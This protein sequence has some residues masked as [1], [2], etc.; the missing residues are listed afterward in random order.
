[1]DE[2]AFRKWT[3]RS[4]APALTL[5]EVAP[6]TRSRAACVRLSRAREA[7]GPLPVA[8]PRPAAF[9]IARTTSSLVTR[10]LTRY[11]WAPAPAMLATLSRSS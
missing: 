8:Q 2:F 10:P 7:Q 1:M 4:T 5:T 6:T 11:S 3:M 9:L